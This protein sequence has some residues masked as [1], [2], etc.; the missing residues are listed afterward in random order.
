[1]EDRETEMI[2]LANDRLTPCQLKFY[3]E[4]DLKI[5]MVEP[6][7]NKFF[8]GK[9]L[10]T[11]C[12]PLA[13]GSLIMIGIGKMNTLGI[14]EQR[15][16]FAKAA[17]VM[18]KYS[19]E[20][21]TLEVLEFIK[22]YGIKSIGAMVEG[23]MLGDYA[24]HAYK[25]NTG[26]RDR[27]IFL[28]G[29]K[30]EDETNAKKYLKEAVHR[31][32]GIIFTRNMVNMPGNHLR[33]DD[34]VSYTKEFLEGTD[35]IVEVLTLEEIKKLNMDALRSVGESSAFSPCFMVLK[36][37]GNPRECESFALVGKGVTCDTGGYCLKAADSM[38]GI[39]G[40]MAGGAS[41]V[42]AF[43]AL[44]KNTIKTNVV[45]VIPICENRISTSSLLPG[46]VI[47]S[48]SGKTIEVLNTD[49]EGRLILAD[50]ITY[51]L[52]K[53]KVTSL[54]TVATLT[55]AVVNLFGFTITGVLTDGELLWH[56]FE[57]AYRKS[58]E[59]FCRIP[60]YKEHEKMIESEI[61][62]IKNV[63]ENYCGTI[64]AG[65][66][67]RA[68]AQGKPWIHLDIAGTAW[69]DQPVFEYQTKGATGASVSTIYYLCCKE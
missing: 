20:E 40:D 6:R 18:R 34:F 66:F 9:Y 51:V 55:G 43:Y 52:Q 36:Y 21:C 11:C 32:E 31:A 58:G 14:H 10:Q 3:E 23:L 26:L 41:V 27:K 46:D 50:A 4:D 62:D 47:S 57:E 45:G 59:R 69:V 29:I 25:Q 49:A 35:I 13:E 22:Q 5:T 61:A 15:E 2:Q 53:E 65:L 54:L 64:T 67:L 7:I 63:G 8:Q 37:K 24:F 19:I 33:P 17:K 56:Q 28:K 12:V 48:M 39:K 44:A 42:G 38:R 60:F 30:K 68:F 1:M 16:I